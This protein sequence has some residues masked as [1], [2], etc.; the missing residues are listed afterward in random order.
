LNQNG[1]KQQNNNQK[2]NTK[3]MKSLVGGFFI[4]SLQKTKNK[5]EGR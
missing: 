3:K 4:F 5:G 1:I 2:S